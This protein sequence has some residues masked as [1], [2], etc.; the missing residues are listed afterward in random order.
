MNPAPELTVVVPSH[1]E[2]GNVARLMERLSVALHGMPFEVLFVDDLSPDGTA[3]E[4]RRVAAADPR[5][6][7]ISRCS[8]GRSGAALEGMLS[9]QAATVAVIDADLQHDESLLPQMKA[10]LDSEGADLVVVT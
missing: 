8:R 3:A 1:N 10:K 6:R 9:A 4:V 2:R 5:C 7:L